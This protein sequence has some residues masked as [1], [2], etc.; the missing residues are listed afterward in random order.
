MKPSVDSNNTYLADTIVNVYGGTISHI[1]DSY[2]VSGNVIANLYDGTI[3]FYT[4]SSYGRKYYFF[5]YGS[6]FSI[7]SISSSYY[8]LNMYNL[9]GTIEYAP[10]GDTNLEDL[11]EKRYI[12]YLSSNE[13]N[14]Y[15]II[16]DAVF[17]CDIAID[18]GKIIDIPLGSSLTVSEGATLTNNGTIYYH[19]DEDVNIKGKVSGN[20]LIK[21]SYP[22]IK[23][24]NIC[25]NGKKILL[26]AGVKDPKLTRIIYDNNLVI[27]DGKTEHDLSDVSVYGGN[28]S[29]EYE[30]CNIEMT[31]GNVQSLYVN[32]Y[33]AN[34]TV[35][36]TVKI[37]GGTIDSLLIYTSATGA[38]DGAITGGTID[39]IYLNHYSSA[40]FNLAVKDNA[41]I[42]NY[43]NNNPN[44]RQKILWDSSNVTNNITKLE[45]GG[46]YS[47]YKNAQNSY[48]VTSY[49]LGENFTVDEGETLLIR[50]TLNV[51]KDIT[52][53]LNGTIKYDD[54]N[55]K[56][57][58]DGS[59]TF[60][61]NARVI[62]FFEKYQSNVVFNNGE[63][64]FYKQAEYLPTITTT[65]L[66]TEYT[67]KRDVDY[68]FSWN[69]TDGIKPGDQLYKIKPTSSQLG[70]EFYGRI[71][72][73]R[74]PINVSVEILDVEEIDGVYY[75][76]EGQKFTVQM[77]FSGFYPGAEVVSYNFR[78]MDMYE[79]KADGTA[80]TL[81]NYIQQ[82]K[83]DN[84]IQITYKDPFASTRS[85]TI[86]RTTTEKINVVYKGNDYYLA[87]S[88]AV[89]VSVSHKP[90]SKAPATC[91]SLAECYHC[92]IQYGDY[93]Y[94]NHASSEHTNGFLNCCKEP[95]A[96]AFV[97]GAYQIEN[98][99]NLVWFSNYVNNGDLSAKAANA[100]LMNDI[101]ME[102]IDDFIPIGQTPIYM[103][104]DPESQ[105]EM[106]YLGTFDG[107]YKTISNLSITGSSTEDLTYGLFGTLN[108]K[109]KNLVI[110]NFS[111][112]GNGMDSRVGGIA[113]QMLAS[114]RIDDSYV[115]NSS[116]N[117]KVNTNNG[118]AGG[119]VGANYGGMIICAY[120]Y[121]VSISAGRIGGIAGDNKDDANSIYR[122]G[123]IN[124]C[125]TDHSAITSSAD[126]EVYDSKG[127]CSDRHF[128]GEV[129]YNLDLYS[130]G[131]WY[132]NPSNNLPGFCGDVIYIC[133]CEG[134]IFYS[135][136]DKIYYQHNLVD[137]ICNNCHYYDV[138]Q[139]VTESN[140]QALSL[141]VDYIGYYAI[142]SFSELCWYS[143]NFRND[144]YTN[145]V[146]IDDILV[147]INDLSLYSINS[148][149]NTIF[150][151]RN[152]TIEF[153]LN[154]EN[155]LT[156]N[157]AL[158][159]KYNNGIFKNVKLTGNITINTSGTVSPIAQSMYRTTISNVSSF[160]NITNTNTN[161]GS[162]SGLVTKFGGQHADD[163]KSYIKNC[164][165]Y[166]NLSGFIAGGLI[167]YSWDGTQYFDIENCVIYANISTNNP[168]AGGAGA[169]IGKFQTLG[170]ST[171][172]KFS[173]IY[174]YCMD[175]SNNPLPIFFEGLSSNKYTL[176]NVEYLDSNIFASGKAAYLLGEA[177]GQKLTGDNK[178]SFP[179][180]NSDVVY[181]VFDCDGVTHLY[182][183]VNENDT[184][185]QPS[186]DNNC[187]TA[188]LCT[189]CG[190]ELIAAKVHD[191]TG[192]YYI[193]DDGH[194]HK[195]QNAN[196]SVLEEKAA[197]TGADDNNCETAVLCIEC[198]YEITSAKTHDFTGE[199]QS[200]ADGHYHKCQNVNCSVLEEKASHT[201]A[202]D[203][204]CETA[205]LCTE[206]GYEITS[207][208]VHDFTGEYQND[209]DGHYHKCQNANCS[210][211]EEKAAH[212]GADDN[213]CETAVF[214]IECNYEITSAKT[215][216]FTGEYQSDADGHYHKCQNANC[217][218]LEE[219]ESHT[220]A[221]DNNCETAVLCSECGYEL[222]AAKTHDFTGE[223]QSDADGHYHKCQ[224][225]NCSVLE[226]K[227]S[228]TG[229]DDNN[230]E[231]AVFCIECNYEIT[232]A[233]THDFTGEY[234]SDADGH[235]H[236]C[237]NA[238]CSVLEEK[239]SHTGADDN[240]CETAVLCSKCGYEIVAAKAPVINTSSLY[241][242]DSA[243][244]YHSC[245][246][247]YCTQKHDAEAHEYGDWTIT[248]EPTEDEEGSK[249][250]ECE[251][252]YQVVEAI[253]KLEK[254]GMPAGAVVAIV[255]SSVAAV[256]GASFCLYWFVLRKKFLKLPKSR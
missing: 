190:Y 253:A 204:N 62:D 113:G 104:A 92:R 188:V 175:S 191:F 30:Y 193:E 65:I 227:E 15:S 80:F 162:V 29:G 12:S 169:I 222:I 75:L 189:E 96:P 151:G 100:I 213:N 106:G 181:Q 211:L 228:H 143:F 99:G 114:G 230:C 136:E 43:Y 112:T 133:S 42:N 210:V 144:S 127:N 4:T 108:G 219:K 88:A 98:A 195:C 82:K 139:I 183:N 246:N 141:S 244:H 105:M 167:D 241:K 78:E 91:V 150:D 60:G 47:L 242:Y 209:A 135:I 120:S 84:S 231:T 202:D 194:Y 111:Y 198:G 35:E 207:A 22:E 61:E 66:G 32:D 6:T 59:I 8:Y 132:L 70:S 171:K 199:Y 180:L 160:V 163:K 236:K 107:N 137:G 14:V 185:I 17:P 72:I 45:E 234:Q 233:K 154:F 130:N 245:D 214:C 224:N 256:A 174:F 89:N 79:V 64:M 67:F 128:S 177:W 18:A 170:G 37:T 116:I 229:V 52:L 3:E 97:D 251:C 123:T 205:V 63:T 2:G 142:K 203:N 226:E 90:Y 126:T 11:I 16:G 71:T 125:F 68:T 247:E 58:G 48:I 83:V 95:V 239:E 76:E 225:V 223:Y 77:S 87:N 94:N 10:Y 25:A 248:K 217:S 192:E 93:D 165:V 176:A 102:G 39:N 40:E 55:T 13:E 155:E 46:I 178:E 34:A 134:D 254:K 232:S 51:L 168:E 221:D 212:T 28:S 1:S 33:N 109:V 121:N 74:I 157:F 206:C 27:I 156:D 255:I 56:I 238:N 7:N 166:G 252:G 85:F 216:D 179:L 147:D 23:N 186:D 235:Y 38:F 50:N 19:D 145:I 172:S 182:K 53:H 152:H 146:L 200:D 201:G 69:G 20:A 119:I 220:G 153:D 197:H 118:V 101:N 148:R 122:I 115:I 129:I 159:F 250:K 240:N 44:G 243:S 138:P 124:T 81:I 249:Y 41:I 161:A 54:Y 117:T 9:G 149:D 131:R 21:T 187:E 5:I 215:H 173:N 49:L 103:N 31:G 184:H 57:E 26:E 110:S 164:G 218:V 208:K 36:S 158:F 196:C 86:V 237:Q 140:Y 24:S 73:H